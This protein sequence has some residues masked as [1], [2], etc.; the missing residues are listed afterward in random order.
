MDFFEYNN[1]L[2]RGLNRCEARVRVMTLENPWD[3]APYVT[4]DNKHYTLMRKALRK[5]FNIIVIIFAGWLIASSIKAQTPVPPDEEP[6]PPD[7]ISVIIDNRIKEIADNYLDILAQLID[8]TGDYA[9]CYSAYSTPTA[10]ANLKK[11]AQITGKLGIGTYNDSPQK[12]IAEI[13]AL[14][15]EL[16]EQEKEIK[17]EKAEKNVLAANRCLRQEL[18][19]LN[20]LL[21]E[22]VT[23]CLEK[24]EEKI[25]MLRIYLDEELIK[26]ETENE[27]YLNITFELE[28]LEK[29]EALENLD[30]IISNLPEIPDI[31]YEDISEPPE[32]TPPLIRTKIATGRD[33]IFIH[34]AGETRLIRELIDSSIELSSSTPIYINNP[35]GLV[36]VKGRDRKNILARF[37]LE[38]AATSEKTVKE[39]AS[40]IS[41]NISYKDNMAYVEPELP[42]LDDPDTKIITSTLYLQV[43]EKNRLECKTSFG[44]LDITA[45]ENDVTINANNT[46][47]T[48]HNI[49]GDLDINN[50]IG[51]VTITHIE[52]RSFIKNTRGPIEVANCTGDLDIENSLAPVSIA[53]SSGNTTIKNIGAVSIFK[54][55][56][57]VSIKNNDGAIE[58]QGLNG[59][60]EAQNAYRPITV[61]EVTG[62]VNLKNNNSFIDVRKIEGDLTADIAFGSISLDK[63]SGPIFLTGRGSDINLTLDK[64]ITGESFINNT[65]GLINLELSDRA[66]LKLKAETIGG[67]IRASF[68]IDIYEQG[69]LQSTEIKL[70]KAKHSLNISGKNT[71]INLDKSGI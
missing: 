65:A 48:V 35:T 28:E 69:Q 47:I 14:T 27:K 12:L 2:F 53:Y 16:K 38:I 4:G 24:N 10:K 58:V 29:L 13:K 31:G 67:I 54:H 59:D 56:G 25:E 11:L 22:D 30:S 66:N 37:E 44:E 1:Y 43:P 63:M 19:V 18:E 49:N 46:Q 57:F 50:Y 64:Q 51:G 32:V 68:P 7:K 8:L 45:I 39:F 60:L 6:P 71:T 62:K 20:E 17:S 33:M 23:K 42:N 34:Q 52:G 41:L 9:K 15:K 26:I 5:I 70:G 3:G 40:E 21:A 61:E 55:K 36:S